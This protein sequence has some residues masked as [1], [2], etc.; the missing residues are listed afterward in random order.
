MSERPQ[1][2]IAAP[3]RDQD[4]LIEVDLASL[5]VRPVILSNM[6]L[7][8]SPTWDEL[9]R[10]VHSIVGSLQGSVYQAGNMLIAIPPDS[11]GGGRCALYAGTTWAFLGTLLE[12]PVGI[13]VG[14]AIVKCSEQKDSY[15][16]LP[17]DPFKTEPFSGGYH[18]WA[19]F[20]HGGEDYWVDMSYHWFKQH[21]L[22]VGPCHFFVAR[23]LTLRNLGI[24]Y[25]S[26]IPLVQALGI[27]N[28]MKDYAPLLRSVCQILRELVGKSP[29][30]V[31]M[32]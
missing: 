22:A 5:P 21:S 23:P 12:A 24:A 2:A 6:G 27:G 32:P 18:A 3:S 29:R 8:R 17:R 25:N 13:A 19:A 10:A 26:D 20:Q 15:V 30:E 4:A 16:T 7:W 9:F 11:V 28:D 1:S 31:P 14:G